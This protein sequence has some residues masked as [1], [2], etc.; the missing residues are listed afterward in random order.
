MLEHHAAAARD[1]PLMSTSLGMINPIFVA[2]T[3]TLRGFLLFDKYIQ[4]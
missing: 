2:S 1:R 3:S 4:S